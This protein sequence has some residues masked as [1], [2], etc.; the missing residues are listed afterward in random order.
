MRVLVTG[1]SGFIGTNLID[2]LVADHEVR[3]FDE[4]PPLNSEH[5][6]LW[7]SGSVNDF[8]ALA[9]VYEEHQ[10]ELV[11]HLAARTDLHGQSVD[12][13][14]ANTVGIRNV[15]SAGRLT[16][17]PH[18]VYAS[19]RLV[20]AIDH[21]PA[22]EYDYKPST[23]YGESKVE[24]E[25]IVRSEASAGGTWTLVRPTSIWGPWFGVPYRD[26]FD[27]VERGRY[28]KV[29]GTNPQKSYGFVGNAVHELIKL[30][31]AHRSL[32]DGRVFWLTDYPPLVLNEW[33]EKIADEFGVKR[34]RSI[35]RWPLALAA[36]LGDLAKACGYKEPPITSFRLNNLLSEMTYDAESTREIVGTLPYS[37]EEGVSLTIDWI[38]RQR[39]S[40]SDA[41]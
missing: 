36:R 19:S 7:T 34:P 30:G 13:Y 6:R 23:A 39:A 37:L 22:H 24:S 9:K 12:D 2:A 38:R 21:R 11:F 25:R 41:L 16:S 35:P 17:R 15:I 14:S 3:S 40:S 32:V 33:A 20:F 26:F 5:R 18:T 4:S 1:G 31:T 29:R 27:T 8:D 28:V 10:P